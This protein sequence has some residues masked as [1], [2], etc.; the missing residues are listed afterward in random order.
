MLKTFEQIREFTRWFA[1]S[2]T[3]SFG[4][5]LLLFAP[6]IAQSIDAVPP[7][8]GVDFTPL[9]EQAI[10]VAITVLTV[11]A[12]VVSKFGVSWFASKT[13]MQD[14]QLEALLAERV[15]DILQ[16]SIDY[17]EMWM[18][19]EVANPNSQIKN[20]Q[21]DNFYVRTAADYAIPAMPDLI[22]FFGLTRERIENLIR[23]RLNGITVTPIVDSG[24]VKTSTE[25][26]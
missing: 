11:I 22:K 7:S 17:A 3:I 26:A 16:R 21:I 19:N 18:K 25:S 20:V 2:F 5:V 24:Q 1:W 13:R 9:A 23:S 10:A 15:N 8:G 14:A 12:G 6:A 4:L